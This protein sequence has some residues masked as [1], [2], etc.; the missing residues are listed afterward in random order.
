M[1]K[2]IVILLLM[3]YSL[4]SFAYEE[5][6]MQKINDVNSYQP[7][8]GVRVTPVSNEVPPKSELIK[9][10]P[11]ESLDDFHVDAPKESLLDTN[12]QYPFSEPDKIQAGVEKTKIGRW[13]RFIKWATGV[14][15]DNALNLTMFSYHT[16][17]KRDQYNESHDLIAMQY[18]G[19]TFG[20]FEN[21]HHRT[22]LFACIARKIWQ[23]PEWHGF[24]I[25][26][27]HKTGLLSGYRDHAPNIA[28]ISPIIMPIIGL[29]YKKISAD[30]WITPNIIKPIFSIS[31]RIGFP[32][33]KKK[34]K[35]LEGKKITEIEEDDLEEIREYKENFNL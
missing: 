23:S 19:Y 26:L 31:M 32:D 11:L 15:A 22:S 5:S 13:D 28:N 6:K 9:A 30:I 16:S 27:Q 34:T 17:S 1:K 25:D 14:P 18:N 8:G 33:F 10:T 21:S 4:P 29:N 24:S 3:L 20:Y 35:K 2:V 7:L 12:N